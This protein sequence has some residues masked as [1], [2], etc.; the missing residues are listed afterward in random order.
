[1]TRT[2]MLGIVCAMLAVAG[3]AQNTA[4]C[5]PVGTWYGGGDY[6]YIL[7]ITPNH[8]GSFSMRGDGAYSF[9][10]FGYAAGTSF[11]NQLVRVGPRLYVSQ[12]IALFTTSYDPVPPPD[13]YEIDAI[14]GWA[15]MTDCDHIWFRYDFFA[16]YF[17]LNKVPFVDQPDMNYLPPGGIQESYRRMPGNCP[18]CQQL[19]VPGPQMRQRR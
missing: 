3:V 9:A 15:V 11:S 12:G 16:A 19:P 17:D 5:S 7:T 13:S 18:A 8:D 1:M 2:I 14:R 10:A 6:R 4:A